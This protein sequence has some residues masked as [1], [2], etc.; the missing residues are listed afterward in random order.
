MC[1]SMLTIRMVPLDENVKAHVIAHLVRMGVCVQ[2]T[3]TV[4]M[5]VTALPQDTA[6]I[7]VNMVTFYLIYLFRL[8][9]NCKS[10]DIIFQIRSD[11]TPK[12]SQNESTNMK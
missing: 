11:F 12:I 8:W 2:A 3:E 1:V 6:G 4:D 7:T 9:G 5:I 10:N